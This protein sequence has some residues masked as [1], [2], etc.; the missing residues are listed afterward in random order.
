[1]ALAQHKSYSS[2]WIVISMMSRNLALTELFKI[3][4]ITN[5][6]D[7]VLFRHLDWLKTVVFIDKFCW[8]KERLL[9]ALF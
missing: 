3:M 1:M 4:L 8:K 9:G 7:M 6:A 5:C 2:I